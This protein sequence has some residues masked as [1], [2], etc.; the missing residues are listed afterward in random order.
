MIKLMLLNN[1][2]YDFSPWSYEYVISY[3]VDSILYTQYLD[4]EIDEANTI[5]SYIKNNY[6]EIAIR[7]FRRNQRNYR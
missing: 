2:V 4:C 1:Y 3:P 6:Y 7:I 5:S